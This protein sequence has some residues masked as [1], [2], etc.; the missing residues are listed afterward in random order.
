MAHI[1]REKNMFLCG[2]FPCNVDFHQCHTSCMHTIVVV[3]TSFHFGRET[4]W[5]W[6]QTM[7]TRLLLVLCFV[8]IQCHKKHI[9][10]QQNWLMYKISILCVVGKTEIIYLLRRARNSAC[11]WMSLAESNKRIKASQRIIPS[12]SLFSH[13][14]P[15]EQRRERTIL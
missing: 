3:I 2:K 15:F 9:R 10:S 12:S 8:S 6:T 1:W 4:Y 7:H 11:M 13:S 5:D 14:L